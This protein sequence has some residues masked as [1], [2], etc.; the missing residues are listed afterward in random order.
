MEKIGFTGLVVLAMIAWF[1]I[2]PWHKENDPQPVD[3]VSASSVPTNIATPVQ[4]SVPEKKA[5]ATAPKA[6]GSKK[7][8]AP[9]A[10]NKA[11][12]KPS[13]PSQDGTVDFAKNL[14]Q[15]LGH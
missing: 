13:Q 15:A 3:E 7:A 5:V 8:P 14:Q 6:H 1:I 11:A 4:A 10:T 9:K 12:T 2:R